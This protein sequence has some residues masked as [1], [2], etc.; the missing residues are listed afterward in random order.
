VR[1]DIALVTFVIGAP[2]SIEQSVPGPCSP[3]FGR[4]QLENL[5]L[6]RCQVNAEAVAN[7]FVTSFVN[8]EIADFDSFAVSLRRR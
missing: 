5:K 7:D 4:E 3:G 8:H 1:I 6:E 2:H